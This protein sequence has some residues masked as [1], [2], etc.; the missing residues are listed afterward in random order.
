M[1]PL[2]TITSPTQAADIKARLRAGGKVFKNSGIEDHVGG[3]PSTFQSQGES[4]K[5]NQP[6]FESY[7]WLVYD[8]APTAAN[9]NYVQVPAAGAQFGT[10]VG[11]DIIAGLTG[12]GFV[13]NTTYGGKYSPSFFESKEFTTYSFVIKDYVPGVTAIPANPEGLFNKRYAGFQLA[14]GTNFRGRDQVLDLSAS[15]ATAQFVL[16]DV[17]WKTGKAVVLLVD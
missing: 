14:T 1:N 7:T 17:N 8:L 12:P 10:G 6:A 2:N 15:V 13:D 16:K 4:L 3:F 9:N 5:P 11:N